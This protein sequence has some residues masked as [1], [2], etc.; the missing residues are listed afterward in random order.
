MR[1]LSAL[2][3]AACVLASIPGVLARQ[4]AQP[5]AIRKIAIFGSSVANGTGDESGQEGY[6]GLLRALLEPTRLGDREQVAWR[7]Q[8]EAADVAL[9][10]ERR[11]GT[12]H[13]V[14]AAR[15]SRVRPD[16]FVPRQRG[17]TRGGGHGSKGRALRTVHTRHQG[18]DRSEPLRRDR[19]GRHALLHAKRLHRRGVQLYTPRERRHQRVGC[20]ERQ[21]ARRRRRW[22][23][24]VGEWFLV[25]QPAPERGRPRGARGDVRPVA[26]RCARAWEAVAAAT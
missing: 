1:R 6:A 21:P 10:A 5:A 17:H 15:P 14:P 25:G 16:R 8:H 3:L 2:A 7:R 23:R 22:D 11:G 19:S 18:P 12:G 9:R 4:A 26:V 13:T 20:A 24:Q